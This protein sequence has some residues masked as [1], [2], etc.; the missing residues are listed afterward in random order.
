MPQFQ[1]PEVHYAFF[2]NFIFYILNLGDGKA[3]FVVGISLTSVFQEIRHFHMWYQRHEFDLKVKMIS[4]QLSS[5]F[6]FCAYMEGYQLTF[7][8]LSYSAAHVQY[9]VIVV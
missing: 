2:F 4:V 5:S 7:V 1:A 3:V 6:I 8:V 9:I